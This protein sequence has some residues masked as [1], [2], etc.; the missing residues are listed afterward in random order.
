[1][2]YPKKYVGHYHW[3]A[4]WL[5]DNGFKVYPMEMYCEPVLVTRG[6]PHLCWER[7]GKY[8]YVDDERH[9]LYGAVDVVA[10]KN[11]QIWAFEVKHK[12]DKIKTAILQTGNYAKYF[13]YSCVVAEDLK[14]L[15]KH[16][17]KFRALGVGVYWANMP[18]IMVLDEP[19]LQN[20]EPEHRNRYYNRF[21]RN[22]GMTNNTP[23]KV[24][25][26]QQKLNNF[27]VA[28]N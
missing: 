10:W 26:A 11:K 22:T 5:S 15:T 1:M 16:R 3:L 24:D 2:G 25:N 27:L 21:L 13:D 18:N 20:P 4:E 19:K 28:T 8:E 9:W 14:E 17:E 6:E 23:K 7:Y 12:G